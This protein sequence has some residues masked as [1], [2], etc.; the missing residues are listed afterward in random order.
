MTKYTITCDDRFVDRI[1]WYVEWT[2]EDGI[3]DSHILTTEDAKKFM[4]SSEQEKD[5]FLAS[6]IEKEKAFLIAHAAQSKNVPIIE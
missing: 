2:N 5:D 6:E 3:N 4:A 1:D